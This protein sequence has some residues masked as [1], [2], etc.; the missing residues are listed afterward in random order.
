M[1][2]FLRYFCFCLCF[3]LVQITRTTPLLLM[4]LHLSQICFTEA[5]TFMI[6]STSPFI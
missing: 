3:G 6:L 4:I 1:V 2:A 5:R